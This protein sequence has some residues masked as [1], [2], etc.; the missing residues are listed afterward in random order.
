MDSVILFLVLGLG[1]GAAYAI[2]ALGVVLI[3]RG[4]GTVNFAQGAIAM[5]GALLFA[6]LVEDGVPLGVALV[7][8]LLVAGL[9]GVVWHLLVMK[10]LRQAPVLAKIVA[11][12]GLLAALQGFALL[13]Y[14]TDIRNSPSLLPSG[15]FNVS[16]IS[17]GQDRLWLLGL[18]IVATIGLWAWYRF[19]RFGIATR[20]TAEN[21]RGAALLG[22][23]P[24]LIAAV[25]WAAGCLLGALA[26][27]LLA[28]I[29]GLNISVL[30]LLILPGLAAALLGRFMSFGITA[31][32]GIAIGCLQSIIGNF[33][34]QAGVVDAFPF[35]IVIIAL[36]VGGRSIPARGTLALLRQPLAP[37]RQIGLR[38]AVVLV[39]IVVAGLVFLD[40]YYRSALTSSLI[41]IIAALSV[42]VITGF[43]GQTSLMPMTF[44]GLGG[45][46]TSKFAQ[47]MGIPFP[48]PLLMAAVAMVPIGIALGLPALR[49]RGLNLAVVTMGA[50][51]SVT[52][53]LFGNTNWTGGFAGSVVPAPS[54]FGLDLDPTLH[55]VAFAATCLVIAVLVGWAVRNLRRSPS[56]LRMLAV[57]SNERAAAATG[58]GVS[59]T[60]L[61]AFAISA[62]I[63]AI[64]G[65]LLSYQIGAVAYERFDVFGSI[66]M[67]TLVYIGGVAVVSGAVLAGV[68]ASGGV[69]FL[70]LQDRIDGFNHYYELISGLLLIITVVANPD[71]VVIATRHQIAWL[72]RKLSRSTRSAPTTGAV[73]TEAGAADQPT[74]EETAIR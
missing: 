7:A 8:V 16:G 23:S 10:P 20:A 61:Q 45:F 22:F 67:I 60:K 21:E 12:L 39:L 72:R 24:D 1:S 9:L 59:A 36:I 48:L 50:A 13:R 18:T 35:V 58:V 33:S 66:T 34:T 74:L 63:A 73:V 46:L 11:T 53:V 31:V 38:G 40:D 41:T 69:L 42:T 2:L 32:A 29:V 71:G 70:F 19:S 28:P 68:G 37:S 62:A 4:S 51:V 44:A 65:S 6:E 47:D 64:S 26:G 56:G 25:N 57:R 49:V 52:A 55:P 27:I 17:F 15:V 3:Q 5:V 14:G 54:L 30:T 43:V